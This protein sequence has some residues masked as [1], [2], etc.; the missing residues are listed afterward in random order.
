MASLHWLKKSNV[1]KEKA[2]KNA[3]K[4]QTPI[5]MNFT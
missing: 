5:K 3:M 4:T 2:N 1:I